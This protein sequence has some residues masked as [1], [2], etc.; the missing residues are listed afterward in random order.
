MPGPR[1]LACSS[2]PCPE[3]ALRN[4]S[5]REPRIY[6]PGR[7]LNHIWG[8]HFLLLL[9]HSVVCVTFGKFLNLSE[10]VCSSVTGGANASSLASS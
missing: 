8:L 9:R 1:L 4:H 2:E 6:R 10:P 3:Q 5:E 7:P